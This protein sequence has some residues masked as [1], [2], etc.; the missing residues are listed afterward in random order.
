MAEWEVATL[1]N[2]INTNIKYMT[3]LSKMGK[4]DQILFLIIPLMLHQH[5]ATA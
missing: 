1:T 4:Q 2:S 3:L 5:T